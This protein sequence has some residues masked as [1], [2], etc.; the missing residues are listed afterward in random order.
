MNDMIEVLPDFDEMDK[1][2][3]ETTNAK[4]KLEDAKNRLDD[5]VARCIKEATNNE[6]YWVNDKPP[7][8]SYCNAVIARKGNTREDEE[9]LNE[10]RAEIVY[11]EEK[12]RLGKQVLDNMESRISVWQT[13]SANKRKALG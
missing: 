4:A 8:M 6:L 7:S 1:V 2:G 9:L 12:Y 13:Y 5:E 3:R 11:W 10:L